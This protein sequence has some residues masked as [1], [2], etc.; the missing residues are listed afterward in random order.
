[1]QAVSEHWRQQGFD[2]DFA[3]LVYLGERNEA[4]AYL[5]GHGWQVQA[6][7]VN[8]LL[9]A[10]GRNTFDDDEPMA[11]LCYLSAVLGATR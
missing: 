5:A 6:T 11:K 2:L 7:S 3:E 10:N 4:G 9:A 8:D 1:M